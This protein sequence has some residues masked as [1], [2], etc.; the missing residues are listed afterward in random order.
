MIYGD[1]DSLFVCDSRDGCDCEALVIHVRLALDVLHDNLK[2]KP[3]ERMSLRLEPPKASATE[4]YTGLVLLGKMYVGL[5]VLQSPGASRCVRSID[6][7]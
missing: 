2:S 7:G 3:F 6:L 4:A 5:L 1:T